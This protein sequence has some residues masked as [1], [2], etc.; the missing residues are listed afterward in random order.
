MNVGYTHFTKASGNIFHYILVFNMQ[1]CGVDSSP[2]NEFGTIQWLDDEF[3]SKNVEHIQQLIQRS[4]YLLSSSCQPSTE[5]Y[6]RIIEELSVVSY[7]EGCISFPATY[8]RSMPCTI[9]TILKL[10]C[11]MNIERLYFYHYHMRIVEKEN[12]SNKQIRS[13]R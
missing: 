13:K 5:L 12:K 6:A 11:W 1:K 2:A 8:H 9:D 7:L 3:Y 4:K 10:I